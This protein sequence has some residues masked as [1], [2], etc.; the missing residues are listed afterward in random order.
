MARARFTLGRVVHAAIA[1]AIAVALAALWVVAQ[2]A[3]VRFALDR[4]VAASDGRLSVEGVEGTLFEGVRIRALAWDDPALDGVSATVHEL[5][6]RWRV[7]AL[8]DR[9]L[10]LSRLSASSVVVRT[11]AS[12]EPAKL[13]ES[14]ELP[15]SLRLRD[16]KVSRLRI[17]AQ[18]AQAIELAGIEL[19]MRYAPGGYR[20]ERLRLDSQWGELQLFGGVADTAPFAIS[21]GAMIEARLQAFAAAEPA[22][23]PAGAR[24]GTLSAAA[25]I[26]GTLAELHVSMAATVPGRGAALGL[27]SARFEARALQ[28]QPLGPIEFSFEA[29]DPAGLG[30]AEG[31][32]LRLT[33]SGSAAV[34]LAEAGK[35]F[36]ASARL[37][38]S[39]SLAGSSSAGRVPLRSAQAE[40]RW[41]DGRLELSG[42]RGTLSGEGRVAGSAS[43]DTRR[44]VVILGRTIAQLGLDLKVEDLDLAQVIGAPQPTRLA[45]RVAFQGQR[46]DLDLSDGARGG[47]A[48]AAVGELRAGRLE[49]ESARLRALAGLGPATLDAA[50]SVTLSAPYAA[51]LKGRFAAL[52]PSRVVATVE[53]LAP[54]FVARL[55]DARDVLAK[56]PGAID[57]G[58]SL[59]GPLADDPTS[60]GV[61]FTVDSGQ[62]AGLAVRADA[63]ASVVQRRLEGLRA[64]VAFG[65]TRLDASGAIGAPGD[66]LA[67]SLR[68]P[69]LAQL[70]SLLSQPGLAGALELS[71]E[72][73]GR[74]DAP[75]IDL[76]AKATALELP[77]LGSI[78]SAELEAKLSDLGDLARARVEVK[79]RLAQLRVGE[80]RV[81]SLQ[82]ELVGSA[83]A[84]AITASLDADRGS[85]RLAGSGSLGDGPRW[86]ATLDEASGQGVQGAKFAAR[87]VEPVTIDASRDSVEI[88]ATA[89]ESAFGR[90]RVAR[91]SW[92]DGRFEIEAEASVPSLGPPARAFGVETPETGL[93]TGLDDIGLELSARLSGTGVDDLGGSVVAKLTSPPRVGASGEARLAIREAKLSGTLRAELPSFA[94]ARKLVGP[95][96]L[97]DGR[98]RFDGEVGGTLR[99][100]RLA[101]ELRGDALRLEQRALGWRLG[102]GTLAGR[103]DGDRF[104]LDSLKLASKARGGGSLEMRGEVEAATLDGRFDF[105]ADRL[106]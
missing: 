60:L 37:E 99:A 14:L 85:L 61:A 22:G 59:D 21:A 71:A 26:D 89:I 3:F 29:V 74:F 80:Q 33:G 9:E 16:L 105:V 101:G 75:A 18:G 28:A 47:S 100:P 50:G 70:A 62:L 52:D 1:V 11:R 53:A 36:S 30:I 17:E 12:D 94:F 24:P 39:N 88:G 27:V 19:A 2:T 73:A 86:R 66:R 69:R 63:R 13:P 82:F 31:L 84:H 64:R 43:V 93:D 5:R 106:V 34:R 7:L 57:G 58:W 44:E 6:L 23:A 98:L 25:S 72:V 54:E 97:F 95:E 49:L 77:A 87:L 51:N 92:R 55:A 42:L 91:A 35:D 15:V 20:I 104:R 56:L 81:R 4:A 67:L 102:E 40:L 38:A 79:G 83:N 65:E 46:F 68:A 103:F 90:V 8:L 32:E 45:G 41:S 10:D 48:L 78:G 76:V 96:W